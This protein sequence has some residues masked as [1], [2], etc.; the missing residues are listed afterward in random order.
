VGAKRRFL[1]SA[2]LQFLGFSALLIVLHAGADMASLEYFYYASML[3]PMAFLAFAA[4][5][6]PLVRN[7]SPRSFALLAG[8]AALALV[9]MSALPFAPERLA[10]LPGPPVLLPLVVGLGVVVA[11]GLGATGAMSM[12]RSFR[13]ALTAMLCLAASQ[14]LARQAAISLHDFVH[15]FDGDARGFFLQAGR[16]FT[17][18][19][20]AD[21]SH[22]LRIWYERFDGDAGRLGDMIAS[23]FLLCPRMVG[24]EF[25]RLANDRM[26]DGT[27]LVPGT[28][29]AVLSARPDAAA[30]AQASLQ[31]VGLAGRVT[32]R[33]EI[34]GPVHGFA[35]T[36]LDIF[37]AEAAP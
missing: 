36:F 9:A 35:I 23:T 3:V 37:P 20:D 2:Q 26:C 25:P 8:A 29:I 5:V 32:A 1:V 14:G 33:H 7:L 30:Q 6:E 22:Q 16:S 15:H 17:L 31:G 19:Q 28:R 27:Q 13:A 34:G 24:D 11:A 4:Q 21:P 12:R 18:L 10:A